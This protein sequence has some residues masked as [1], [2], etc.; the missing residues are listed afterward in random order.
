MHSHLVLCDCVRIEARVEVFH[1]MLTLLSLLL[2]F[3]NTSRSQPRLQPD[4]SRWPAT[5]QKSPKSRPAKKLAGQYP[6]FQII[7]RR[8]C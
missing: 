4:Y 7:V 2:Q 3:V 8:I 6:A 1:V 5:E